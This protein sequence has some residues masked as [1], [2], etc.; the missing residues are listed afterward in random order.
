MIRY[1]LRCENEDGFEAWF[2]NS[3]DY[4]DQAA[5]GLI[6]CPHCGSAAVEK[7]VMAPAIVRTRGQ[8]SK[9]RKAFLE[10]A[11]KVRAHIQETHDYVGEGFVAEARAM[12]DGEAE[13]RP[14]WG[15][16]KPEEAKALIEEGA[17]VAPLPP[18]LAPTPPRKV[19]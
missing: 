3:A 6:A 13:H 9:A 4:D 11:A 14:I 10:A 8:E 12:H 18:I 2:R 5:R 17:P 7:A 1:E 19:N 16:A 15:E